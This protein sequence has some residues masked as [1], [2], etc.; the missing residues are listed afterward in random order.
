MKEMVM[1]WKNNLLANYREKNDEIWSSNK[2]VIH[3]EKRQPQIT[4]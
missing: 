2:E 4:R 1:V 3:S